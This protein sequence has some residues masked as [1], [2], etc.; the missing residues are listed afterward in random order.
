MKVTGRSSGRSVHDWMLSSKR[1]G[2]GQELA[3]SRESF[4]APQGMGQ[5][6]PLT[7]YLWC[8]RHRPEDFPA[9]TPSTPPQSWKAGADAD[10]KVSEPHLPEVQQLGQDHSSRRGSWDSKPAHR[11]PCFWLFPH[12]LPRA[13][14]VA[15]GQQEERAQGDQGRSPTGKIKPKWERGGGHSPALPRSPRYG[16]LHWGQSWLTP[17]WPGELKGTSQAQAWLPGAAMIW[18]T[19]GGT[20]EAPGGGSGRREH[21]PPGIP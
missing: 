18:G 12:I 21:F 1:G 9:L 16:L 17:T 14:C 5:A 20:E 11:R 8:T 6:F 4:R 7:K 15:S 10:R 3:G 13:H 19:A 2:V